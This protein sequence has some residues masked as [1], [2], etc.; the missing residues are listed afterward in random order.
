MLAPSRVRPMPSLFWSVRNE[1]FSEPSDDVMSAPASVSMLLLAE[2]V[3]D[4]S[5]PAVFRMLEETTMF[6]EFAP[7][8]MALMDTR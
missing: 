5:V 2:K 7:V 8:P 3:S 6:P 1:T 4:A